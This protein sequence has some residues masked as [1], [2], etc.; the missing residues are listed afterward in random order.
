MAELPDY[1]LG[2][3]HK[4]TN[5]RGYVGAGWKRPDWSI[6]IKLD[7]CTVLTA[8]PE[9]VIMLFPK[10]KKSGDDHETKGIPF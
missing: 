1:Q 5:Q 2:V 6:S 10:D 9:L 4:V 7:L 3:L 8:D